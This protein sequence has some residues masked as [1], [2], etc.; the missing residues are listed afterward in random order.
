MRLCG[1]RKNATPLRTTVETNHVRLYVGSLVDSVS[2]CGLIAS[3]LAMTA[4]GDPKKWIGRTTPA[5]MTPARTTASLTIAVHAAP[6]RP[7]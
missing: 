5:K 3:T 7:V 4:A 6:R 1:N 2:Q